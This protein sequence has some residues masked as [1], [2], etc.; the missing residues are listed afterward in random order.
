V[1]IT[2]RMPALRALFPGPG[3]PQAGRVDHAD[4]AHKDQV[5]FQFFTLDLPGIAGTRR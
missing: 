4:Q 2:V 3:E 1:I 5:F